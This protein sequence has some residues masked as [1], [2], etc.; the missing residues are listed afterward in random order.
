MPSSGFELQ[1]FVKIYLLAKAEQQ[2]L[3]H[4]NQ[5]LIQDVSTRWN[6]SFYMVSR[7]LEQQQP[8]CAAFLQLKKTDLMPSDAEFST[9]EAY[10]D[11]MKPL[12]TITEAI[13]AEKWVTI[14]TVRPIL[15]KLLNSHLEEAPTDTQL[16]KKM[17]SAMLTDLK[18]W[19]SHS[20]ML[21]LCK[22]AFLDPQLK[23]LPFLSYSERNEIAQ[24][25][26]QEAIDLA[27]SV[28]DEA[29][30]P[31]DEPPTA[32]KRKGEHELFKI[33]N[34]IM[35]PEPGEDQCLTITNLQKARAEESR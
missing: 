2:D 28:T 3:H 5:S 34:S 10:V 9:M 1:S 17:K 26:E 25:I 14:S 11:V 20:I 31:T 23:E 4:P 16:C 33:I 21:Q 7:I 27:E 12:V 15:Y 18:I 6:S 13:G 8:L 29:P 35:N 32:K 19:L 22:A 30:P 24:S